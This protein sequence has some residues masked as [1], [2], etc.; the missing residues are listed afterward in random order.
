MF[1]IERKEFR[2][3]LAARQRHFDE[4]QAS[5][6]DIAYLALQDGFS[7]IVVREWETRK[8]WEDMGAA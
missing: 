8:R 1:E 7:P 4:V 5:P 6:R 2:S 3:W